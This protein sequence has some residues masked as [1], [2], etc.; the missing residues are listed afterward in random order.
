M[1]R[2]EREAILQN[3]N[4]QIKIRTI[5]LEANGLRDEIQRLRL[6]CDKHS[7]ELQA[8]EQD[9]QDAQE[10]LVIAREELAEAKL[11]EKR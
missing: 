9:L 3:E 4:C 2:V 7:A 1:A 5:E 6:Q 11:S 10:N 8:T